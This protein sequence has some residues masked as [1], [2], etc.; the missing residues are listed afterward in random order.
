MPKWGLSAEMREQGPYGLA[1]ELLAPAKVVTD[2]IHGDVRIT[3]LELRIIDSPSFQR[4]R[5]VRQLGN[6]HL[7]YP[8]ATH[9]RFSH[10]LGSLVAAQM[11]FDIVLEQ[12]EGLNPQPD[13]F[14]EW[15]REEADG[16]PPFLKRVAEAAVLTRLGALLHDLC[17]IP[18]GHTVEDELAILAPHDANAARFER[19]WSQIDESA[20]TPIEKGVS[21]DGNKLKDDLLPMILSKSGGP[22]SRPGRTTTGD[23]E[24]RDP[25]VVPTTYPFSQ[26]IVGNTVSADLIDYLARDH[27]FTGLPAALGHRFLDSFYVSGRHNPFKKSQ[28]M[29]LRIVRDDRERKDTITELLKF[30]R[31]RYELS[32]RALVHHGKLAADAMVGKLLQEYHDGLYADAVVEAAEADPELKK[33]LQG[34]TPSNVEAIR[35]RMEKRRKAEGEAPENAASERLEDLLLEHGDD[36][37][38]EHARS[39][40]RRRARQP[41]WAGVGS[42]ADALLNRQLFKPIARMSHSGHAQRLWDDYG[43]HPDKRRQVEQAAAGFAGI[44]KGWFVVLW[45]PPETM[46]LKPA[47]ALVD[48]GELV[49]TLLRREGSPRGGGRGKDIYDAHRNLW[50]LDVYAHASVRDDPR[51]RDAVLAALAV[52]LHIK[53]W[54]RAEDPVDPNEVALRYA[55]EE[56]GLTRSAELRLKQAL[57]SFFESSSRLEHQGTLDETI[58]EMKNAWKSRGA[59]SGG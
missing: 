43:N 14:A 7:V 5:R 38:L 46:R 39:E 16:G 35:A 50:A 36:G 31:Y 54:D 23:E 57:P 22:K 17:H 30:L 40:G 59:D 19:Q 58:D 13:L 42:I 51:K 52:Q 33:H 37:L 11:L 4:L 44:P 48:D 28:R 9:T 53:R 32:E 20:R 49:D 10:S 27:R 2:P 34:V 6:T 18:F 55:G 12:R 25:D 8:A 15:E 29:V 56:L 1:Q 26:D 45:I 24:G 3:T 21:L 47:L 41:R